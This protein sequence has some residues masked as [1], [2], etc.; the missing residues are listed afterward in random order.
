MYVHARLKCYYRFATN[1]QY[2]FHA[3]DW[4]EKNAV[5]SSVNFAERKQFQ[6]ETNVGQLLNHDNV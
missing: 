3:L 5:A 2:I 4:I 1:P 6:S